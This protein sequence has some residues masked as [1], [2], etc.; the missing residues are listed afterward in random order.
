M[1][2]LKQ[3][4]PG[5]AFLSGAIRVAGF[6]G[7]GAT[8]VCT[9]ALTTALSTAGRGSVAV[10]VQVSTNED[11]I[12][13]IASG[14]DNRVEVWD[15]T[16]KEKLKD[17]DSNEVFARLTEASGTY[18]LTYYSLVAGVETA[19]LLP[20]TTIDFEFGYRFDAA[21]TPTD[22]AIGVGMRNVSQDPSGRGGTLF[23]ER[24]AVTGTN[25]LSA[26]SKT[27]NVPA[28]V[29]LIVENERYSPLGG[30]AAFFAVSGKTLTWSP[31]NAKFSI[32]TTDI[33]DVA[34]TTNE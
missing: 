21:R 10:P 3:L 20:A 4:N 7:S 16:T 28:N 23:T 18:T 9:T 5:Q 8:T 33:V 31:S 26:L 27:P 19:Y 32:D 13:V 2:K 12:G 24:L 17:G 15:G 34:Y 14:A 30:G 11:V 25:T 1:G 29:S 22:I 6:S